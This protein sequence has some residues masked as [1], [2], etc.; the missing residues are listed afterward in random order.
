MDLITKFSLVAHAGRWTSEKTL[1]I[2][3]QDSI[4]MLPSFHFRPS[5]SQRQ[6]QN[7][8]LS[9]SRVEP[10]LPPRGRCRGMR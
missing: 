1:R 8:N 4:A 9:V 3:V 6:R 10:P 5:L 2:Y 7:Y